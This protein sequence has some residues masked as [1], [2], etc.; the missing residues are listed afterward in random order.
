MPPG[1]I[2][3]LCPG[4][5]NSGMRSYKEGRRWQGTWACRMKGD[6]VTLQGTSLGLPPAEHPPVY[7]RD[8]GV[9]DRPL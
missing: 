1:L 4:P 9:E 3:P 7:L 8:C 6:N 2:A 5:G